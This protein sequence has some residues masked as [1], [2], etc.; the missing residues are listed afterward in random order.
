MT[1]STAA[2]AQLIWLLRYGFLALLYLFLYLV[3]RALL[4]DLRAN[5][6]APA[7]PERRFELR[8]LEGT[9]PPTGPAVPLAEVTTIGRAADNSLCLAH[10]FVSAHHAEIRRQGHRL[11]VSDLGSTNGTLHNGRPL[12]KPAALR[13]GD[14]IG[15][16][17]SVFELR[18][19]AVPLS[20]K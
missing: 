19:E 10:P 14:R 17:D 15:I 6:P 13:T 16:G 8:W 5:L 11:M 7:R 2:E 18:E 12:R 3:V 1:P 4:G 20:S 9:L